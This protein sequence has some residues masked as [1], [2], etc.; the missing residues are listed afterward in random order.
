VD[1]S[2]A[3]ARFDE[4]PDDISISLGQT[5]RFSCSAQGIPPPVVIWIKNNHQLIMDLSRMTILPSG[6]L[7]ISHVQELDEG[8]YRCNISNVDKFAT[9]REGRL[10]LNR[11]PDRESP[12][13]FTAVPKSQTVV[14][15][16]SVVLE[17]SAVGYPV[18]TLSWLKN[19]KTI[20]FG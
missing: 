2:V 8:T 18:P 10:V 4:E 3:L 6:S 20:D 19:G 17:C 7:E 15:S 9:S 16:H 12:P 11:S 5:A 1:S 13:V 14:A